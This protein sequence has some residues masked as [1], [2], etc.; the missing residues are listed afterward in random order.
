[1]GAALWRPALSRM[2]AEIQAFLTEVEGR[3]PVLSQ[4]FAESRH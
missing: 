1:M 3:R 2:V 4:P